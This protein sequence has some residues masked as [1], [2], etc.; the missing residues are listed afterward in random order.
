[1]SFRTILIIDD[2][3][4]TRWSLG[5]HL[6]RAGHRVIEA[7]SGEEGLA[8]LADAR[9][10]LVLLD[11]DLPGLDGFDVL[12]KIRTLHP[13]LRVLTMTTDSTSEIARR[14]RELGGDAHM[15]K[16][17]AGASLLAVVSALL[18]SPPPA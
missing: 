4:L 6:D 17:C 13:A 18:D 10:D 3:R 7:A 15:E 9:P 5:R 14:V 2:N 8:R 11:L 16:P 1:M 12:A